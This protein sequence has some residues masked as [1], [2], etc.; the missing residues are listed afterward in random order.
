MPERVTL[1]FEKQNMYVDIFISYSKLHDKTFSYRA[2]HPDQQEVQQPILTADKIK[3]ENSTLD[4]P[5]T[6]L[7]NIFYLNIKLMKNKRS[8]KA[9]LCL[10]K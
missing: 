4:R 1:T 9:G 7:L 2:L 6:V 8:I 5:S 3:E 10:L